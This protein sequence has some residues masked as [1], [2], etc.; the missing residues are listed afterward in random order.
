MP[1]EPRAVRLVF[2]PD[3]DLE[4]DRLR[5]TIVAAAKAIAERTGV[6]LVDCRVSGGRLELAVEGSSMLAVGL[7]AELRRT[8]DRWHLDREGTHLWVA[9]EEDGEAWKR[10]GS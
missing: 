4:D 5:E 7:A 2:G 3:A 10:S 9:P 8:T 1:D 6:R